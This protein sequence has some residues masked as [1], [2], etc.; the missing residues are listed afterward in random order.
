MFEIAWLEF[1]NRGQLVSRRKAFLN[2]Y[3]RDRFTAKLFGK[4]GFYKIIAIK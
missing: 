3:S 2:E 1:N 4:D